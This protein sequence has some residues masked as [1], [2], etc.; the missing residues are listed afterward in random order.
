MYPPVKEQ[1]RRKFD[2]IIS[3]MEEILERDLPKKTFFTVS[4]TA[5]IFGVSVKT[6]KR[7]INKGKIRA[8]KTDYQWL[9]PR[10]AII[11]FATERDN[12]LLP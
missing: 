7:W 6:V 4:E 3:S 5:E 11:K 1:I 10:T 2:F 12:W 9:V 8:V